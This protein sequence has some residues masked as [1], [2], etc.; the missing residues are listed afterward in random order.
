MV[1]DQC[2]WVT[3][4]NLQFSG[5]AQLVLLDV[6]CLGK[7][8]VPRTLGF[9]QLEPVKVVETLTPLL[10]LHSLGPGRLSPFLRD[11]VGFPGLADNLTSGREGEL[12]EKRSQVKVSNPVLLSADSVAFDQNLKMK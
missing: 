3:L 4:H 9:V 2:L 7:D 6:H 12:G 1:G 10:H 5:L 11:F 8:L